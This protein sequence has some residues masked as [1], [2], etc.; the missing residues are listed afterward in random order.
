MNV[1]LR[2]ERVRVR[3]EDLTAAEP[4]NRPAFAW[5][6]YKAI[7]AMTPVRL[8]NKAAALRILITGWADD[9]GWRVPIG[10][11]S[12]TRAIASPK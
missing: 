12:C 4:S 2:Q 3:M 1:R 9:T 10:T 11:K 6:D 5:F 8:S 7:T